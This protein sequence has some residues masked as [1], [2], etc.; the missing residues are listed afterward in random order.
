MIRSKM[1]S[2]QKKQEYGHQAEPSNAR[3]LPSS[4]DKIEELSKIQEV[5]VIPGFFGVTQDGD[6]YFLV[7]DLILLNTD[8]W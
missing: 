5:I 4:Y 3:I 7:V 2:I 1:A 8:H 6:I